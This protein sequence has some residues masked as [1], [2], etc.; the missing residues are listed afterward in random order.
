MSFNDLLPAAAETFK[1]AIRNSLSTG[2]CT[3][4]FNKKDGTERVMQCTIRQSLLPISETIAAPDPTPIKERKVSTESMTV[5]DLD[6]SAWK[7]FRWDG[8]VS[9]KELAEEN[10]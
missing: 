2:P 8:F 10:V 1:S 6:N 5:Y 4:T 9:I 3:V 7:S